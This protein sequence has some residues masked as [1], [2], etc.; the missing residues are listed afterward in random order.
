MEWQ[1]RY[2]TYPKHRAIQLKPYHDKGNHFSLVWPESRR[3]ISD[4]DFAAMDAEIRA[5]LVQCGGVLRFTII[6]A[7]MNC[8]YGRFE[9]GFEQLVLGFRAR[10]PGINAGKDL[11]LDDLKH[12][13]LRDEDGFWDDAHPIAFHIHNRYEHGEPAL[14]AAFN[15]MAKGSAEPTFIL[16]VIV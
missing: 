3:S 16:N 12:Q 5:Y 14:D 6:K 1:F 2:R 10:Y 13:H 8:T 15:A 11:P 7:C 4:A 9:P